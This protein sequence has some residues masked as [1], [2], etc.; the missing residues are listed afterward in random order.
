M[1]NEIISD[2]LVAHEGQVANERIRDL[3]GVESAAS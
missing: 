3:L 2:T 1:E